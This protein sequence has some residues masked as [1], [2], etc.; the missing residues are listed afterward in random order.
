MIAK[1]KDVVVKKTKI[2]PADSNK[3]LRLNDQRILTFFPG[4]LDD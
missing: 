2:C 1:I 3:L 4:Y